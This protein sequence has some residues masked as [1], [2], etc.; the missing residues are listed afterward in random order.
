ME[1]RTLPPTDTEPKSAGRNGD[2]YKIR[3]KLPSAID[4][5]H[6]T[7]SPYQS[8]VNVK[9]QLNL[10]IEETA[11][12]VPSKSFFLSLFLCSTTFATF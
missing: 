6:L 2:L 7:K 10:F 5:H 3:A 8:K 12:S 1:L 11:L 4:L 9:K